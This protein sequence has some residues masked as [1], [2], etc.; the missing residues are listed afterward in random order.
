[1][2]IICIKKI[3]YH[4]VSGGHT[5]SRLAY[6]I[7]TSNTD[8]GSTTPCTASRPSVQRRR[9]LPQASAYCSSTIR[10]EDHPAT[11]RFAGLDK[12]IEGPAKRC[13]LCMRFFQFAFFLRHQALSASLDP[14]AERLGGQTY[15]SSFAPDIQQAY[16]T[17]SS[18]INLDNE[19]L[20]IQTSTCRSTSPYL[21][22][23][24]GRLLFTLHHQQTL[25]TRSAKLHRY[26]VSYRNPLSRSFFFPQHQQLD[27]ELLLLSSLPLS[28]SLELLLVA[29]ALPA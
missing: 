2:L 20:R 12:A 23:H 7:T 10:R 25:A 29:T 19:R 18:Y 24:N 3:P 4:P 13:D 9:P 8:C 17:L 27:Q 28:H 1:V 22:G 16:F 6:G 5:I 26:K 14:L 21:H 15:R 11:S